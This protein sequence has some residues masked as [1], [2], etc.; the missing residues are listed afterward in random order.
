MVQEFD[1]KLEECLSVQDNLLGQENGNTDPSTSDQNNKQN[2]VSKKNR[3]KTQRRQ[4][5]QDK[6]PVRNRWK[7][8]NQTSSSSSSSESEDS[9]FENQNPKQKKNA[10][11]TPNRG[12][13]GRGAAQKKVGKRLEP[14]DSSGENN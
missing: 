2:G 6:R 8:L 11:A 7:K 10:V 12:K 9:D 5:Q 14:T 1:S 3:P 4:Q 13:N